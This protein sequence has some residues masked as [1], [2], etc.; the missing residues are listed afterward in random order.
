MKPPTIKYG[1]WSIKYKQISHI[2]R[3]FFVFYKGQEISKIPSDIFWHLQWTAFP[4]DLNGRTYGQESRT[5]RFME[6]V[7]KY[8]NILDEF[9][10]RNNNSTRWQKQCSR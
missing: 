8:D 2:H 7:A 9:D 1:D 6:R 4:F 3:Y 10:D 5:R